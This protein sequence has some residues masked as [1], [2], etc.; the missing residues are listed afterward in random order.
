MAAKGSRGC[1]PIIHPKV[2]RPG[3]S[4]MGGPT[5]NRTTTKAIKGGGKLASPLVD[6]K[7]EMKGIPPRC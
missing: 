3:G 6:A 1:E 7:R 5:S 2:A 4:M